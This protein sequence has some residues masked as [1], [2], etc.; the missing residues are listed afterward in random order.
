MTA[1]PA[2]PR[3][4]LPAPRS[5]RAPAGRERCLGLPVRAETHGSSS[6]SSSSSCPGRL[7]RPK[8]PGSPLRPLPIAARG[9]P[10]AAR[11]KP[12]A[13]GVVW[14]TCLC[15]AGLP[16]ANPASTPA[17]AS[18]PEVNQRPVFS[19]GHPGNPQSPRGDPVTKWACKGAGSGLGGQR[20]AG[21]RCRGRSAGSWQGGEAHSAVW[22]FGEEKAS[23]SELCTLHAGEPSA[24]KE[25]SVHLP[26]VSVCCANE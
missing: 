20:G 3:R 6:A 26:Y 25:C 1:L 12:A 2:A 13:P 21:P 22:Y 23:L 7:L 9:V 18:S 19:T 4:P 16:P 17:P 14:G 5:G 11:L 15:L 24:C 8:L 10:I